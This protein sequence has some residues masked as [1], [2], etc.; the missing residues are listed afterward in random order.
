MLLA[1]ERKK[2]FQIWNQKYLKW[3]IPKIPFWAVIDTFLRNILKFFKMQDSIKK[4]KRF[5]FGAKKAL[6]G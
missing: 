2:L 1:K 5:K 6:F 3:V 4:Y